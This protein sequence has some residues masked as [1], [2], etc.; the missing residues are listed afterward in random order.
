MR[1]SV[2]DMV[3]FVAETMFSS[4]LYNLLLSF[5]IL[6]NFKQ[7]LILEILLTSNID[8]LIKD[9]RRGASQSFHA[10]S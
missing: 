9:R 1:V 5:Q 4:S 2:A 8:Q 10:Q 7:I 3:G 6:K